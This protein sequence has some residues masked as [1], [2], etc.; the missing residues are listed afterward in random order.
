MRIKVYSYVDEHAK[1]PPAFEAVNADVRLRVR[2]E[3]D[4]QLYELAVVNNKLEL[5]AIGGPQLVLRPRAS[6]LV[7]VEVDSPFLRKRS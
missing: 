6:N 5:I 2:V 4:G 3:H 7:H 1:K